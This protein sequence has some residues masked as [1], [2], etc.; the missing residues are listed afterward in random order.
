MS[1][2][3]KQL[4]RA[5]AALLAVIMM[6]TL[7]PTSALATDGPYGDGYDNLDSV[8]DPFGCDGLHTYDDCLTDEKCK[9][10]GEDNL[11]K[12]HTGGTANC[13]DKAKCT[14]CGKAYGEV[15]KSNHKSLTKLSAVA[16][17]CKKTG[18][19]EGKKCTAC[20][21]TTVA[22]KVVA[23]KAHSYGANYVS[24]AATE[25]ATGTISKKCACG[26]VAYVSTIAKITSIKLSKTTY[27]YTGKSLKPSVTVKD[28][29]GNKL[30]KDTD[31]TVKYSNNKK[32]GK[33]TVKVTFKGK[34]SGTKTL[35]FKINPKATKISSLKAGKKAFTVKYSKQTSGSGYEIQYSTSSKFKSAKTVKITKNK[36]VSKTVKKLKAK[37]TYYVRVRVVKGSYK[38]AWSKVSKVKTKK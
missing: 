21:V 28:S 18:L 6:F 24:K 1:N 17:T 16:A 32:V 38:S 4:S 2:R 8:V 9:E 37:K 26:D 25:K 34:Y 12:A 14:A 36:T 27:T 15:D 23:K 19:T 13:K 31:Y 7:I 35:T 22:Q 3:A 10:C 30:V 20:G 11:T 5:L 29:K 33:A